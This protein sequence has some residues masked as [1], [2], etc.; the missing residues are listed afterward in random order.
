[1]DRLRTRLAALPPPF[2]L[3]SS[4]EDGGA[5]SACVS[6]LTVRATS[7]TRPSV[8]SPGAKPSASRSCRTV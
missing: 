4:P 3:P 1:M 5:A 7:A 8:I 6:P 2:C